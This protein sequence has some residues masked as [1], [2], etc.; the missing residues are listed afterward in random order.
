M[1]DRLPLLNILK[2][3]QPNIC[4][5]FP[6]TR[7]EQIAIDNELA[8]QLQREE[9]EQEQE[10][11]ARDNEFNT[12]AN[13]DVNKPVSRRSGAADLQFNSNKFLTN[14]NEMIENDVKREIKAQQNA[15]FRKVREEQDLEYNTLLS[16]HEP[17]PE[18]VPEPEPEPVPEPE[19]EP[20]PEPGPV[21]SKEE[22]R[23]F[24]IAFFSKSNK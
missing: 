10:R 16:L 11:M 21:L 4:S 14:I 18:P 2:Q 9:E 24:R 7:E 6:P 8:L 1:G 15:E 5:S 17:E 12:G 22:L 19:P 20:V 13:M 3:K 23:K